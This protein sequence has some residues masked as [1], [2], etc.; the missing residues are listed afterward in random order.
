MLGAMTTLLAGATGLVGRALA[1]SWNG[2]E[3]LHLLVR[4]PL[5][6]D[7]PRKPA[8]RVHLVDFAAL[9]PLPRADTAFCALGTTIRTAGSQQAFRA[10]DLDAVLAFARAASAAG[11]RRFGLVSALGADPASRN[12]YSR[13]KGEAEAALRR[14]GFARLVIAQPSLLLGDRQ[15]LG[16]PARPAEAL[17][18]RLGGWLGP[19]LP[20]AWRPVPAAHVARAL[21]HAVAASG[22]AVE[23]IES[24]RLHTLGAPA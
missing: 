8:H 10:V 13:V 4:R 15:A 6:A 12:F 24:A 23:I 11:V 16:Q 2:S 19:V 14:I 9:P 20:P 22:P 5:P 17:G 7:W 21:R 18:Q 3:P 1:D